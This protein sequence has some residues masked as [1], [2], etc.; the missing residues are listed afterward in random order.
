MVN[1]IENYFPLLNDRQQQQLNL[2]GPIYKEWNTR[3]N[4]ISRKDIDNLYVNHVL[5]SL[6]IGK[7]LSP[8]N[9]TSFIDIGTGGGFPGIPMAIVY[10]ECK[11]HLIDRIR[12]KITVVDAIVKELGLENVTT[13]AGDL[14]ECHQKFDFAISRAVMALPE[15]VKIARKNI[16]SNTFRNAYPNGLITL[17]GGDLKPEL[18]ALHM[19][20][21]DEKISLWFK[22]PYFET[23]QIVYVPL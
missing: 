2:L 7:F 23:K 15:L 22:E 19:D 9:G 3:I 17:K 5:H 8:V 1:I 13:Q 11:F 14:G 20:Y 18:D 10:P 21:I 4:V 16:S 6:A 12:K